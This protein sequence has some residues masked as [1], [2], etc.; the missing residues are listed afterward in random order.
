MPFT[1]MTVRALGL[2]PFERPNFR[3]RHEALFDII[4]L[5]LTQFF[6]PLRVAALGGQFFVR[7]YHN[8]LFAPGLGNFESLLFGVAVL[9]DNEMRF[10]ADLK[11]PPPKPSGLLPLL[12]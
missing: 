5:L 4:D 9:A 12:A 7:Q 3:L 2:C 10:I 1:G 6:W 11:P 8:P